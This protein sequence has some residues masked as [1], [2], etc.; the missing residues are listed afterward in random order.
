MC[1]LEYPGND[2]R[3]VVKYLQKNLCQM[4]M[5]VTERRNKEP[6]RL[7]EPS[8]GTHFEATRQAVVGFRLI[9]GNGTEIGEG[10]FF[11]LK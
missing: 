9:R 8:H 4:Y 11:L 3:D 6:V 2:G 7:S 1:G 5:C 10:F